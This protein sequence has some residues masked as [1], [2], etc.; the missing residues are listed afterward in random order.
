MACLYSTVFAEIGSEV[1]V[2]EIRKNTKAV[3]LTPPDRVCRVRLDG[4]GV[5]AVLHVGL[6]STEISR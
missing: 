2:R 6:W 5:E 4:E 1:V 3:Q